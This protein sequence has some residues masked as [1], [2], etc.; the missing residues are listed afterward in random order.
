LFP[1]TVFSSVRLH[2][3]KFRIILLKQ[4]VRTKKCVRGYRCRNAIRPDPRRQT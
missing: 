2:R 3:Q 1:S 4:E